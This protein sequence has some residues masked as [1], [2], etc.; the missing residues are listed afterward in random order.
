MQIQIEIREINNCRGIREIAKREETGEI[1]EKDETGD[2]NEAGLVRVGIYPNSLSNLSHPN[3]RHPV[4]GHQTC[5]MM[6]S[7]QL[8]FKALKFKYIR[9]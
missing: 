6:G 9:K 3:P 5:P 7:C 1:K 4:T 2:G 8:D